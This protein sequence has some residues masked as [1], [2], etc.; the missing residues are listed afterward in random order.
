M[1]GVEGRKPGIITK[2]AEVNLFYVK[3]NSPLR[4]TADGQHK[5]KMT[6]EGVVNG[7]LL[8]VIPSFV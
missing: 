8:I 6:L 3:T 4:P 7:Y 1:K 2:N 5:Q